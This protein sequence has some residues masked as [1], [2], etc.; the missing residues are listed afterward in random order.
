MSLAGFHWL[1]ANEKALPRLTKR[2]NFARAFSKNKVPYE[3]EV[4][5]IVGLCHPKVKDYVQTTGHVCV[6]IKIAGSSN[7]FVVDPLQDGWDT[8]DYGVLWDFMKKECFLE[9]AFF[10]K[11]QVW[12]NYTEYY[13]R[14]VYCLPT[15]RKLHENFEQLKHLFCQGV[16][17][18]RFMTDKQFA[19]FTSHLYQGVEVKDL[20]GKVDEIVYKGGTSEERT[21]KFQMQDHHVTGWVVCDTTLNAI[22]E[23]SIATVVGDK[24]PRDGDNNVGAK[25]FKDAVD[26]YEFSRLEFTRGK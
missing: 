19:D 13:M 10:D 16:Y 2:V 6:M 24:R 1:H 7:V 14:V 26:A 15:L 22:D 23:D 11:R 9:H 8:D 12:E 17:D 5:E 21:F 3:Y 20:E 25:R 18:A 4:S